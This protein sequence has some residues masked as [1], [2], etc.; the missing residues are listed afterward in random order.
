[1]LGLLFW[2]RTTASGAFWSMLLGGSSAV[3]WTLAGEPYGFSASWAGWLVSFPTLL[4]V[5]LTT[6]HGTEEQPDLFYET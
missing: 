4:I 1:M 3:V 6:Q 2:R 5:S